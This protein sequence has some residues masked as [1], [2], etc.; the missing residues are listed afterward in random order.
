[1]KK[2]LQIILS[3]VSLCAVFM[4][5]ACENSVRVQGAIFSDISISGS[6]SYGIAVR[7]LTDSRLKDKYVD[8]QV[9]ADKKIENITFWEDN[10]EKYTFS[11]EE[12]DSWRSITTILVEGKQKP[13]TE[14]FEK[15]EEATSRRY[16]FSAKEKVTLVFRVVAG[17][18]EDNAEKTG[19][20]L[21]GSEPISNEFKLK[22]EGSNNENIDD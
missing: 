14:I 3:A 16:L 6:D 22:V 9:K 18:S 1:M 13:K 8:V 21:T 12:A 15:F 19:K 5:A 11:F 10:G 7:F 17:E 2:V 20:V 4:F